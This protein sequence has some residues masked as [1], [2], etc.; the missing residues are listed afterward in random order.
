MKNK[1]ITVTI[2][3]PGGEESIFDF[4]IK[5]DSATVARVGEKIEKMLR[6]LAET[7]TAIIDLAVSR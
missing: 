6:E 2:E 5:G 4:T 7:E 1:M 3:L